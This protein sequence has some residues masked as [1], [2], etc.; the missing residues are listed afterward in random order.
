MYPHYVLFLIFIYFSK[1]NYIGQLSLKKFL[2]EKISSHISLYWIIK[3]FSVPFNIPLTLKDLIIM[4]LAIKFS[5]YQRSVIALIVSN[6]EGSFIFAVQIKINI[7]MMQPFLER[8]V[9]SYIQRLDKMVNPGG[10]KI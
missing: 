4:S 2:V 7:P 9:Y 8:N 6:S 1:F 3:L 10:I 5:L